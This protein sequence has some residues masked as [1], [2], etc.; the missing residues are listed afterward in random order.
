M[1]VRCRPLGTTS[2]GNYRTGVT[3]VYITDDDLASRKMCERRRERRRESSTGYKQFIHQWFI[4]KGMFARSIQRASRKQEDTSARCL[5]SELFWVKCFCSERIHVF[6][7]S[8]KVAI[9]RAWPSCRKKIIPWY[10]MREFLWINRQMILQAE[11]NWI[12]NKI[13]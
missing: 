13:K 12:I 3:H 5:L 11:R 10:I 8:L 1:L 7:R 2:A 4:P 9:S 6:Y